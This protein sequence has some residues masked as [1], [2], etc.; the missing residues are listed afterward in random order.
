MSGVEA[1]EQSPAARFKTLFDSVYRAI[2]ANRWRA[3]NGY[4][5]DR[6]ESTDFAVFFSI[7]KGL[8]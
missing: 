3:E 1:G 8:F 2:S 5:A 7:F 6:N 4:R